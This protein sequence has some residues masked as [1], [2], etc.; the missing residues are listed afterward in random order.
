MAL[1]AIFDVEMRDAA[2]KEHATLQQKYFDQLGKTPGI[3]A[4]VGKE[5]KA[6]A[7]GFKTMTSVLLANQEITRKMAANENEIAKSAKQTASYWSTISKDAKNYSAA[8]EKT[9]SVLKWTAGS[10]LVG[11][12]LGAGSLWGIDR[13]A[14]AASAG[15]KS[16]GGLGISYGQEQAFNLTYGRIINPGQFLGGVSEGAGYAGSPQ[17]AMLARLGLGGGT[18]RSNNQTAIDLLDAVR[19]LSLR[20]PDHLLGNVAD[21]YGLGSVG[22]GTQELRN[23]KGKSPEEWEQYKREYAQKQ[24]EINLNDE[25]LK[26]W[27]DLLVTL[28]FSEAKIKS[29]FIDTL[30]P[31]VKPLGALSDAFSDLIKSLVDSGG[32]KYVIDSAA[33][34]IRDFAKYIQGDDFKKKVKEFT[35]IAGDF[36]HDLATVAK[37]LH[38]LI[39][40]PG[41]VATHPGKSAGSFAGGFL[42]FLT[43]GAYSKS[44]QGPT[45]PDGT[46]I[47]DIRPTLGAAANDNGGGTGSAGDNNPGNLR[48]FNGQGFQKFATPEAGIAANAA[49]LRAYQK[50]GWGNTL[51]DI[52]SH[53]APPGDHNDTARLVREASERTKYGPDQNINLG[54]TDTLVKVL[55]AI[56][57][58]EGYGNN[59][60]YSE[61]AIKIVVE[62]PT[63]SPIAV[64]ASQMAVPGGR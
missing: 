62:S 59:P 49:N 18:G 2:F 34:G 37:T 11:G 36:A 50:A 13:L 4:A 15:R 3:W 53:W 20:T 29:V 22:I 46:P 35:D 31:L 23:I 9:W 55:R 47:Q 1:K 64:R 51:R 42:D 16:S 12:L 63:G 48:N 44:Q 57:Q 7:D 24:N 33:D 6:V 56:V 21:Q 54:D 60:A 61:K 5:N 43:F 25:I 41:A 27:Q 10:A 14:Q 45:L 38:Y 28:G 32:F 30:T 17:S 26:Q 39:G 52:I 19:Q 40:T 8:I 58:Q